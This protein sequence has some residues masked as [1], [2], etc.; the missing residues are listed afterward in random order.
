MRWQWAVFINYY[1]KSLTIFDVAQLSL[2]F[3]EN[4][5]MASEIPT[6]M[7]NFLD[8]EALDLRYNTYALLGA[9]VIGGLLIGKNFPSTNIVTFCSSIFFIKEKI[10]TKVV[11]S[12][13]TINFLHIV[14]CIKFIFKG[15]SWPNTLLF[16]L[17]EIVVLITPKPGIINI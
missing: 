6:H 1:C 14:C 11:C 9:L 2:L 3:V 12:L 16:E 7:L 4:K 10:Y 5:R 17:A 8:S 13:I 15:P